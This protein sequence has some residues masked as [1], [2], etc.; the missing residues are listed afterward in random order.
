[1]HSND[2]LIG[3]LLHLFR[4]TI[5]STLMRVSADIL[6]SYI[7]LLWKVFLHSFYSFQAIA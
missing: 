2:C 3:R 7:L 4:E 5:N 6:Y 1:M